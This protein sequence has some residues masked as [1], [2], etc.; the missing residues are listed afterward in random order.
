M[1]TMALDLDFPQE[2]LLPY[3]QVSI[4]DGVSGL[5]E[6]LAIRIS[7]RLEAFFYGR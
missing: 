6:I 3:L 7:V 5:P 1:A 4:V 2:I